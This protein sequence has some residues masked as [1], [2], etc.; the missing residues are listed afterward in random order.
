MITVSVI[1]TVINLATFSENP[2]IGHIKRNMFAID[3]GFGFA[4]AVA[5]IYFLALAVLLGLAVLFFRGMQKE[6]VRR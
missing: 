5:W 2:A 6:K 3:T 1:F 4:S